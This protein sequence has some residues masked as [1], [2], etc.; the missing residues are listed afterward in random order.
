MAETIH[1]FY[2]SSFD[3]ELRSLA[4]LYKAF[5]A[6]P[7]IIADRTPPPSKD[8]SRCAA[9]RPST[10]RSAAPSQIA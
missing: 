4:E 9:L 2:E 7:A 1:D 10:W 3:S 6:E 5:A 8:S